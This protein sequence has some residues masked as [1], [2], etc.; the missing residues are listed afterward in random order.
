MQLQQLRSMITPGRVVTGL[1]LGT[2]LSA[3]AGQVAYNAANDRPI[4][5]AGIESDA[6]VVVGIGAAAIAGARALK[7]S[8]SMGAIAKGLAIPALA[9][10]LMLGGA[11]S[12][13]AL[14]R[15]PDPPRD[16]GAVPGTGGDPPLREPA[17][18]V[19]P[20]VPVPAD[21]E[22]SPAEA[23]A[24]ADEVTPKPARPVPSPTE[25]TASA[26]PSAGQDEPSTTPAPDSE[27]S[28]SPSPSPDA[29]SQSSEP[30]ESDREPGVVEK[31]V[32]A[33]T[34]D[35]DVPRPTTPP[36]LTA[37][38][39]VSGRGITGVAQRVVAGDDFDEPVR[40]GKAALDTSDKPRTIVGGA[41]ETIKSLLGFS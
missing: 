38:M 21:E 3:G 2:G 28:E 27:P 18:G 39:D 40:I 12:A 11:T 16:G 29:S 23:Q 25:S 5:G 7:A 9:G 13:L 17:P 15:L 14:S 31:V 10:G 6:L 1:A 24:G 35:S 26:P 33:M 8:G 34:L 37:P 41:I 36:S 32:K 22:P 30:V 19:Q 4:L 20:A